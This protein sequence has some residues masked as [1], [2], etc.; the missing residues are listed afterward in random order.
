M[1]YFGQP[2]YDFPGELQAARE[3]SKDRATR[4]RQIVDAN[5]ALFWSRYES[6]KV[7]KLHRHMERYGS[8]CVAETAAVFGLDL[9]QAV[10][11][12]AKP[13]P[14]SQRRTTIT[15]RQQVLD[16]K[17]RGV[18]PGGIANVLNISERRVRQLL[19]AA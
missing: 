8:E 10:K 13:K 16:L 9:S 5:E 6:P 7:E 15:L 19:K 17:D 1:A 14:S 18:I 3:R 11:R 12:A 2:N 4:R